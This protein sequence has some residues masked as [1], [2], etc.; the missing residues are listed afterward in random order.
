MRAT[1]GGL[2]LAVGI[3]LFLLAASRESLERGLMGVALL[4]SGMAGGRVYGIV[5][6]GSADAMMFIRPWRALS[7]LL[8]PDFLH[9]GTGAGV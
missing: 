1:Y 4:M 2:S 3:L 8:I 5:V 7:P 6:G 9:Q